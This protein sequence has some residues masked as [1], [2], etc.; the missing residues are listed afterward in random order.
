MLIDMIQSLHLQL[1]LTCCSVFHQLYVDVSH[2]EPIIPN[3][4]NKYIVV[5][6]DERTSPSNLSDFFANSSAQSSI[7]FIDPSHRLNL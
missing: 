4:E 2:K 1:M 5:A 3:T 6:T 7:P